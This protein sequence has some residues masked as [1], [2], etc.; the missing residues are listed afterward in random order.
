[1]WLGFSR[2]GDP[3]PSCSGSAVERAW[4]CAARIRSLG[5]NAEHQ[6]MFDLVDNVFLVRLRRPGRSTG[7][8]VKPDRMEKENHVERVARY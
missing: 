5:L 3:A 2:R 4:A 6:R 8:E 7:V 1:M